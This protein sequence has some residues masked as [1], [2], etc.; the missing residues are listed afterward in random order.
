MAEHHNLDAKTACDQRKCDRSFGPVFGLAMTVLQTQKILCNRACAKTLRCYATDVHLPATGTL[1]NGKVPSQAKTCDFSV[2]QQG[3]RG[4]IR[5]PHPGSPWPKPVTLRRN[6]PC[7]LIVNNRF[8]AMSEP[9]MTVVRKEEEMNTKMGE[10]IIQWNCRGIMAN[11]EEL[12]LCLFV[13]GISLT[14]GQLVSELF[15]DCTRS[16]F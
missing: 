16:C 1:C 11:R 12:E 4:S 15:P 13:S 2:M 6:N 7:L 8:A 5:S 3:R 9:S 14:S 10:T